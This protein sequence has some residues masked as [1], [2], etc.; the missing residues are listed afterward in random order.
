MQRRLRTTTTLVLALVLSLSMVTATPAG[1]VA[2]F[3]DVAGD[4]FYT[5]AVQWMVD[6]DI[7]SGTSP[8]CFSPGNA[9]S[10]G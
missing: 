3:G 4:E 5:D 2:G 7:T 8:G 9:T 10:R 1:A 6:N